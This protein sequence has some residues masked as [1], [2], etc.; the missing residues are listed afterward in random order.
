[1]DLPTEFFG[2]ILFIYIVA[3]R[4]RTVV[5]IQSCVVLSKHS[6]NIIATS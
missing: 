1:M 5:V 2:P 4:I 6:E 3:F